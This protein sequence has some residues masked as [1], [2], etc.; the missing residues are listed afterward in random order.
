[1][2]VKVEVDVPGWL[3]VANSP[4]G[5]CGRRKVNS[6]LELYGYCHAKHSAKDI[7]PSI[8]WR[9]EAWKEEALDDVP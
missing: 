8:A 2:S 6:E 1:M 4:Y 5:L 3:P 9:R 7:V